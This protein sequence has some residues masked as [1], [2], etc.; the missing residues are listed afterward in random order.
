[1]TSTK[2]Q[3][4]K[5]KRQKKIIKEIKVD[6]IN[7]KEIK[8]LKNAKTVFEHANNSV[9]KFYELFQNRGS[10]VGS[11]THSDQDLLRAM[12]VFSCSGLDAVLKQLIKDALHRVIDKEVGA[13]QEFQKF[14]ERRIKKGTVEDRDKMIIDTSWIA[15][16]FASTIPRDYLIETLQENLLND[17]LQSRDQLLKVAAFFAITQ[18]EVLQDPEATKEAFNV[19]N[20]I[21]HEMDADLNGQ[22]KRKQRS[23]KD[24]VKYCK[25]ILQIG[26]CFINIVQNK[27]DNSSK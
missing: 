23:S 24:M 7:N 1:M 5:R 10:T 22:K 11:T 17:S 4:T 3:I 14:I 12:L 19:R 21:I 18:K 25:N 16:I 8:E 20:E 13:Q 2:E 9:N 6:S 15:S 26:S 27:I